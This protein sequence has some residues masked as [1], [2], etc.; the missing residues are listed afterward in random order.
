MKSAVSRIFRSVQVHFPFLQDYRFRVQRNLRYLL[1]KTHELDFEVLS[2]L[3]QTGNHL[4]LDIGSNRGEAMQS[5]LMRRPDARI[6]GF[7]PNVHLNEKVRKIYKNDHRVHIY[8]FGLGHETG[9]LTL[10]I[11][12]YRNYMFDGLASLKEENARNW[13]K[14]RLY[15]YRESKLRI[16][17][18]TCEVKKLD[19]LNLQP[20]FVKIDVQG[21]E[22]EVLAGGKKT[23]AECQPILLIET[24][25]KKELEFLL[26]Y[27]Y[28]PF[29]CRHSRLQPGLEGL[30]VF[31]IPEALQRQLMG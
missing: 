3:P 5:I 22:Y 16:A 18:T 30:N 29:V 14:N 2:K 15:G 11:P 4:F 9:T 17:K 27:L 20:Y 24:P 19:D 10:H 28:K 23:I 1:D 6:I 13:L 31:F 8:D 21:F 26:K 25:G 7:E 12:F